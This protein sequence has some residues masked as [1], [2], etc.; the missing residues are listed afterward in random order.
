M[1]SSLLIKKLFS[2]YRILD[3]GSES[4]A[5]TAMLVL[6]RKGFVNTDPR[7][8]FRIRCK[9]AK[10]VRHVEGTEDENSV[11]GGATE[12]LYLCVVVKWWTPFEGNGKGNA[13]CRLAKPSLP[14][15]VNCWV[16]SENLVVDARQNSITTSVGCHAAHRC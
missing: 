11:C 1:R 2:G 6:Y 8:T 14:R 10:R 15:R 4:L 7:M 16:H 12:E 3:E 9:V 13:A 5:K